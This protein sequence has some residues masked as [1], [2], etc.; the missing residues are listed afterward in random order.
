[1]HQT[2]LRNCIPR[3]YQL[4]TTAL[5]KSAGIG[6]HDGVS[7][8]VTVEVEAAF[9]ADRIA[10]HPPACVRV[11]ISIREEDESR[12]A[13]RVVAEL[14]AETERIAAAEEGAEGGVQVR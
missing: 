6:I 10:C 12:F 13:V 5:L 11:V 2:S 3:P 9:D 14:R 1:M 4:P 8:A 7:G